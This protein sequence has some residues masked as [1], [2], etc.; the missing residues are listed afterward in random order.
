MTF[1]VPSWVDIGSHPI[2]QWQSRYEAFAEC[3]G[4]NRPSIFSL[5]QR[6]ILRADLPQLSQIGNLN[7]IF[8]VRGP[9]TIRDTLSAAP[10]QHLPE[11]I[12]AVFNEGA[13]SLAGACPN[14]A[15]AMFRLCVDLATTPLLPNGEQP[16]NRVRR[17]LGLRLEWLFDNQKLSE[18]LRELADCLK[19]DGNDGAHQGS[20]TMAD[21]EDLMDFT[22]ALLER[23]FTEPKA[24]ELAKVR[25]EERRNK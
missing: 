3:R 15:A 5:Q 16:S 24:L 1:D 7:T 22:V 14:A 21:A 18:A 10:P 23:M 25:R 8:E 4:C 2:Y 17:S 12:V 6:A 13:R 19:E 20:L 11:N 9:V